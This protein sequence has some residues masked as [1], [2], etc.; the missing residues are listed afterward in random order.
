MFSLI[1][2][3]KR[4]EYFRFVKILVVNPDCQK[5]TSRT[6]KLLEEIKDAAGPAM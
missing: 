5:K 3:E 4:F 6:K 1:I 2:L